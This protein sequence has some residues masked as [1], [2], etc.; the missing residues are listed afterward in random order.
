MTPARPAALAWLLAAFASAC[1]ATPAIEHAT[2]PSVGVSIALYQHG[3][4]AVSV[5]EDRRWVDVANGVLVLDHIDPA[6]ALPSLVIEPLGE[7][8]LVVGQCAR[9]RVT[10]EPGIDSALGRYAKRQTLIARRRLEGGPVPATEGPETAVSSLRCHVSGAPGRHLV[11]V[12]YVSPTLQYRAQ[13]EL[14]MTV[15]DR[16]TVVTRFAIAT[17]AWARTA[18]ATLFD[19]VPGGDP[20]PRE[21]ARATIQLDGST[22]ILAAAPRE[23]PARLHRIY[24]GAQPALPDRNAAWERQPVQ[25]VWVWLELSGLELPPGAMFAHVEVPGE[26]TRDVQVPASGREL[27]GTTIRMPL[28]IDDQL[29]GMRTR[30]VVSSKGSS[31]GDRLQFSVAN[32]GADPREVWIEEPLRSAKRQRLAGARSTRSVLAG[33]RARTRLLVKPGTIERATYTIEYVF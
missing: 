25:A 5:V 22:A 2:T 8:T 19:G 28:W 7:S 14:T 15:G 3:E 6:A 23:A 30:V 4:S 9:D 16:A 11:R 1:H 17:P 12:L 18:T 21:I 29:R 24:R 27:L 13:H 10:Y 31:L 20:S 32:I 26:V 33:D